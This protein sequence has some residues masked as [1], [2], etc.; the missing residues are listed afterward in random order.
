MRLQ[1]FIHASTRSAWT[2]RLVLYIAL[3]VT[4]TLFVQILVSVFL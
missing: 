1:D 2:A 4:V 3:I